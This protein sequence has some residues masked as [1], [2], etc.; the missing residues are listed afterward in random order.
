[1]SQYA[2]VFLHSPGSGSYS[3]Q[4]SSE[5]MLA[6]QTVPAAF[7]E[8]DQPGGHEY[9]RQVTSQGT[10]PRLHKSPGSDDQS[11]D[12]L[13]CMGSREIIGK[14]NL[15]CGLRLNIVLKRKPPEG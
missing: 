13:I 5:H 12:D 1:M 15:L 11:P 9:P 2:P 10:R 4:S 6:G 3:Q 8:R 14:S 7:G